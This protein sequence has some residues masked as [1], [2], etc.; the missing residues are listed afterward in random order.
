MPLQVVSARETRFGLKANRWDVV[1]VTTIVVT[2]P[3]PAALINRFRNDYR[4]ARLHKND[5]ET[6]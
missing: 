5:V 2:I 1:V 4:R 3:G 6:K